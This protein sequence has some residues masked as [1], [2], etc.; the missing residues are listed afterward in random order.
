M[1]GTDSAQLSMAVAKIQF[2]R[3]FIFEAP[4]ERTLVSRV[5]AII[6]SKKGGYLTFDVKKGTLDAVKFPL[7]AS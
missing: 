6:R 7:S 5:I 3:I 1:A 4:S 2:L